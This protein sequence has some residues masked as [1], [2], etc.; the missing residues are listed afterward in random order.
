[1]GPINLVPCSINI[2]KINPKRKPVHVCKR[3]KEAQHCSSLLTW[4]HHPPSTMAPF[5]S[6]L[7]FIL[8]DRITNRQPRRTAIYTCHFERVSGEHL[9]SAFMHHRQEEGCHAPLL[10]RFSATFVFKQK[11]PTHPIS[12][13]Y[14]PFQTFFFIIVLSLLMKV[15]NEPEMRQWKR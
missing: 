14:V 15:I 11:C 13:L 7:T 8:S 10:H 1:M 9:W 4:E 6:V 12:C 3:V 5:I 2:P